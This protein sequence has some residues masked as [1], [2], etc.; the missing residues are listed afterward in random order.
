MRFYVTLTAIGLAILFLSSEEHVPAMGGPPEKLK[1][2]VRLLTKKEG[3]LRAQ[4][5]ALRKEEEGIA[6]ESKAVRKALAISGKRGDYSHRDALERRLKELSRI[7]RGIMDSRKNL[8]ALKKNKKKYEAFLVESFRQYATTRPGSKNNVAWESVSMDEFALRWPVLPLEGVSAGFD[9]RSYEDRFGITHE[10]VD[11]PVDQ[12]SSVRAAAS[13]KVAE[14]NDNGYGYNN[15][16]LEHEDG[17]FTIYGH[18][19]KFTVEEGDRVS[20]GD[21]IAKSGGRPGS[22]GAGFLTTGPHV[23]FET[24][25]FGEAIDPFYY[26]PPVE[27]AVTG[28]RS[29][30]GGSSLR[31]SRA[32]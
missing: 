6:R 22:K 13:G 17:L 24:R 10:A 19:S 25:I 15:I 3:I 18:V 8:L 21:V 26:L 28:V 4:F 23:H 2:E 30:R 29:A 7:E 16:V 11:I 5:E 9:D 1:E 20:T 32:Y 27:V 31:H 12:G 14:V